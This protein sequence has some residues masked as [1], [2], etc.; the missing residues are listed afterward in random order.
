MRTGAHGREVAPAPT[1]SY[2]A[3]ALLQPFLTGAMIGVAVCLVMGPGLPVL[4]WGVSAAS[5]ATAPVVAQLSQDWPGW[6][7]RVLGGTVARAVAAER[8]DDEELLRRKWR[9]LQDSLA[10]T[11]M[12]GLASR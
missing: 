3:A 8:R 12:R 1:N 2:S 4:G 9:M 7:D 6:R 11:W 5:K 10:S